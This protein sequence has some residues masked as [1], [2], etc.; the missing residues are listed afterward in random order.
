MYHFQSMGK[1]K[2]EAK[3]IVA[4]ELQR[5]KDDPELRHLLQQE[6]E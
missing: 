5:I 1:Y 3:Q 6:Q 2:A 4:N